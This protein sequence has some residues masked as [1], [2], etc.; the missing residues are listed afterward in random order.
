MTIRLLPLYRRVT[1][2]EESSQALISYAVLPEEFGSERWQDV[3]T[4]E[5]HARRIITKRLHRLRINLWL[6]ILNFSWIS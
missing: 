4:L 6:V 2:G 3:A 5:W 1:E